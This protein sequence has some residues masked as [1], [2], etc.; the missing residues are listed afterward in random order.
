MKGICF[1]LGGVAGGLVSLCNHQSF[2]F[3]TQRVVVRTQK[4]FPLIYSF[5][6]HSWFYPYLITFMYSYF[7]TWFHKN[8][9]ALVFYQQSYYFTCWQWSPVGHFKKHDPSLHDCLQWDVALQPKLHAP[10]SHTCVQLAVLQRI[11]P[12]SSGVSQAWWHIS[13]ETHFISQWPSTHTWSHDFSGELACAHNI[14]QSLSHVC[15]HRPAFKDPSQRLTTILVVTG[16]ITNMSSNDALK[17]DS[18][19]RTM[20]FAQAT[21]SCFSETKKIIWSNI[22]TRLSIQ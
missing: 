4:W 9:S 5:L 14:L 3:G 13:L 22:A 1:L 21:L 7:N 11:E 18:D 15:L 10:T 19:N 2:H 6:V 12:Q 8:V 16:V 20:L 17:R